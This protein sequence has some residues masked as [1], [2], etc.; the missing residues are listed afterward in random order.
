VFRA[1]RAHA[2]SRGPPVW[3]VPRRCAAHERRKQSRRLNGRLAVVGQR[4]TPDPPASEWSPD[5]RG[6]RRGAMPHR[7]RATGRRGP[8][9]LRSLSPL[10]DGWCARGP[11]AGS[12]SWASVVVRWSYVK[13][14]TLGLGVKSPGCPQLHVRNCLMAD[15]WCRFNDTLGRSVG[16]PSPGE[17]ARRGLRTIY[18][19]QRSMRSPRQSSR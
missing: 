10:V 19:C 8:L 4:E 13:G 17:F 1:R 12:T 5:W 18:P 11:P 6:V 14:R 7:G 15:R 3:V 9:P 2:R 16:D